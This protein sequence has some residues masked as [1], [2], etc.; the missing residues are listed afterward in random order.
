[1]SS[2]TITGVDELIK[3]LG[4]VQGTDILRRPMNE[5]VETIKTEMATY[6]RER[7]GS[8]YDRGYGMIG[9]PRTSERLGQK[10]TSRVTPSS[11]GLVGKI[12]NNVSYGPLVQSQ[13]FQQ[14]YHADT[15]WVTD[16][17]A[18][19]KHRAAIIADFERAIAKA[20]K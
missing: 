12:G 4:A 7:S 8:R 17:G 1:M 9:G 11:G 6:P 13:Q 5:A 2:I 3:K 10:W 14:W 15:G 20:L 18:L 16:Q 19:N